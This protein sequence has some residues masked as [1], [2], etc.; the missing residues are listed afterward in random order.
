V[1][2]LITL[3]TEGAVIETVE[4]PKRYRPSEKYHGFLRMK[5]GNYIKQLGSPMC[6]HDILVRKALEEAEIKRQNDLIEAE[7]QRNTPPPLPVISSII[8]ISR[9]NRTE[10]V[11]TRTYTLKP[12]G[13]KYSLG[14][15]KKMF[16]WTKAFYPRSCERLENAKL[17]TKI[18]IDIIDNHRNSDGTM[19][20]HAVEISEIHSTVRLFKK[21]NL[22]SIP[23][24]VISDCVCMSRRYEDW[25]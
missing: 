2:K 11:E 15:W 7:K 17:N 16:D 23:D 14:I 18:G 3:D 13:T 21:F 5:N 6:I 9:Y 20:F 12:F 10:A 8:P 19:I 24:F 25:E 4:K 1:I 22:T